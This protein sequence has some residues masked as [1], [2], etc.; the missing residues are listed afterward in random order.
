MASPS[1]SSGSKGATIF[2]RRRVEDM[3]LAEIPEGAD[4]K[5]AEKVR[6]S[7]REAPARAKAMDKYRFKLEPLSA[8]DGADRSRTTASWACGFGARKIE[9]GRVKF[10]RTTPTRYA[11]ACVISSIGS[12]PEPIPGST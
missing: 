10:R 4:E 12:I 5:R 9:D 7:A 8:P 6:A 3:P 2:Y 11:A 1:K